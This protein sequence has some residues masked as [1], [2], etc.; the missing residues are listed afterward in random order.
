M[1]R[2]SILAAPPTDLLRN[3]SFALKS[4]CQPIIKWGEE[5]GQRF[6]ELNTAL[7]LS[8]VLAFLPDWN[9]KFTLHTDASQVGAGALP[10]QV[11]GGEMFN[12]SFGSCRFS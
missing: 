5:Q 6:S 10:T 8:I 9:H 4:A 2:D 11:I 3:K 12:I 7:S 1:P